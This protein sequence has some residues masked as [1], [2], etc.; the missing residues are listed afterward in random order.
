MPKTSSL[1]QANRIQTNQIMLFAILLLIDSLHY[2]F[3]KMVQPLIA[4]PSS[5]FYVMAVAT[6]EMAIYAG[7]TGK[8]RWQTFWKNRWFFIA[9]GT[10]IG[11]GTIISYV[12]VSFV[13]PG[14]AALLGK[15]GTVFVVL[16]GMLWLKESLNRW[17]LLGGFIAI[18][19]ASVIA[20]QPGEFVLV[21]SLLVVLGT[22]LYAIHAVIV[23]RYGGDIEFVEFFFWR[24]AVT[25]TM[26]LIFT[27]GAG[28]FVLPSVQAL[29]VLLLAGSIDVTLSRW[30]YYMTMR[31]LPVSLH[32]ILLTLSPVAAILW[33]QI[34]FHTPPT[35]Q[36]LTGGVL[37][38]GG[39][40]LVTLKRK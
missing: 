13:N 31:K 23:K 38:I 17:Q 33:T 27:V 40:L 4:P 28:R 25:A 32:A 3:A 16:F 37:V 12:S 36:Q 29:P 2:V 21:G 10:L 8:L 35:F 1:A 26:L 39:I 22:F 18:A 30:L 24:V 34:F 15:M 11:L 6:V 14:V 9:I 20:F 5:S 7:M 19:G